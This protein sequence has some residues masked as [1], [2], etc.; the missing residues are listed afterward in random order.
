MVILSCFTSCV[1]Y[2]NIPTGLLSVIKDIHAC[3]LL[4]RLNDSMLQGENV[5]EILRS[6][7]HLEY[8]DLQNSISTFP[9]DNLPVSYTQ[10]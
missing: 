2:I 3:V 4:C 9:T 1:Y 6:C 10:K 7:V 5:T 8:L